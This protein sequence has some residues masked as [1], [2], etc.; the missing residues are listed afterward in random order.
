MQPVEKLQEW[1]YEEGATA[2]KSYNLLQ[3]FFVG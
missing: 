3:A 1:L 2:N